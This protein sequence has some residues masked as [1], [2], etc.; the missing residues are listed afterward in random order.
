MVMA[1]TGRETGLSEQHTAPDSLL[2]GMKCSL[3][4][5]W[6]DPP[7]VAPQG[8]EGIAFLVDLPGRSHAQTAKHRDRRAPTLD[9]MLQEEAL[10]DEGEDEPLAA[11]G[12]AEGHP[13]EREARGHRLDVPLEI[14][15]LIEL[16][17][18]TVDR[19]GPCRRI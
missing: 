13:E 15:L 17:E 2:H 8:L 11:D 14:P 18:A 1:I 9:G 10:D 6:P 4:V 12:Q 5:S 19:G 7:E 16:G 3:D